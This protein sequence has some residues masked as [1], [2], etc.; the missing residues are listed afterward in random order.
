MLYVNVTRKTNVDGIWRC[1]MHLNGNDINILTG[2]V[3]NIQNEP[4][5]RVC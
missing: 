3:L 5:H 1:A 4:A 2:K